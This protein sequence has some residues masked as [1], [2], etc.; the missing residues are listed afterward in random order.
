MSAERPPKATSQGAAYASGEHS[1]VSGAH[2][3]FES[4]HDEGPEEL[5]LT[6]EQRQR[7][8]DVFGRLKTLSLY[9]LLGV[10]RAADKKAIKRAYFERTNE[11]HPDR[12]FRKRLGGYKS[13][14][15]AIFG[16]TSEAHD[17]LCS[18]E[19]RAEYDAALRARR[20]S[21]IE[22]ML[23]EASSE[24]EGSEEG[25]R[26]EQ[27]MF[28]DAIRVDDS[29]PPPAPPHPSHVPSAS[30]PRLPSVDAQARRDALA[31]RLTGQRPRALDTTRP[32]PKKT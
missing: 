17:V 7:I 16:R 12:F 10:E 8:D 4:A 9:E 24:M 31:R 26:L 27:A 5:D 19:R 11:F 6:A 28:D 23:A 3:R 1:R 15:E 25:S 2:S 30:P 20:F 18:P 14:M 21:V 13:K 29:E 22:D 32:P